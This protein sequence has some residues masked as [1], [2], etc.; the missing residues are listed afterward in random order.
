MTTYRSARIAGISAISAGTLLCGSLISPPL[1]LSGTSSPTSVPS[2][3]VQRACYGTPSGN[4][5][6]INYSF[7]KHAYVPGVTFLVRVTSR[8]R[9]I[10]GPHRAVRWNAPKVGAVFP[11]LYN[12]PIK[13]SWKTRRG[14][15][16]T[17]CV[18]YVRAMP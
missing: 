8:S 14:G 6:F 9:K 17:S 7:T 13:I 16:R 10:T 2:R 12:I 5:A 11:Y 4:L 1:A 3:S 15:P 18:V